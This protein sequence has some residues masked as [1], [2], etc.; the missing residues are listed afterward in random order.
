[1]IIMIDLAWKYYNTIIMYDILLNHWY[2]YYDWSGLCMESSFASLKTA[3]ALGTPHQHSAHY[4]EPKH[5]QANIP[6]IINLQNY[7]KYISFMVT[8]Q[9]QVVPPIFSFM[10][11]SE[12]QAWSS[13][14]H[15]CLYILILS[16]RRFVHFAERLTKLNP[17]NV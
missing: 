6:I 14:W 4:I 9:N 12:S 17:T 15:L 5:Q 1:M 8:N 11:S 3:N 2:N 7:S 16:E 10:R 13:Q